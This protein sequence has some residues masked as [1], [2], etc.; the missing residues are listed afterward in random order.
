MTRP[1]IGSVKGP[2]LDLILA[3]ATLTSW[4]PFASKARLR[5]TLKLTEKVCQQYVFV[6]HAPP[7]SCPFISSRAVKRSN[8]LTAINPIISV[9]NYTY[10]IT[11]K[12]HLKLLLCHFGFFSTV[13]P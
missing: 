5:S 9:I 12:M 1:L 4:L 6:P 8:I 3:N 7:F 13:L 2:T 11:F 10:F